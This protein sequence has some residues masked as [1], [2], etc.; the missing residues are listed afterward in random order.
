MHICSDEVNAM[1][2]TIPFI[3]VGLA[4]GRSKLKHTWSWIR[5]FR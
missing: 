2:M 3:G 5:R 1:L 4:W